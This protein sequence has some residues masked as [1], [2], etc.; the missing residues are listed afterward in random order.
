M[1]WD[2]NLDA[3]ESLKDL[4]E[5][6]EAARY[7]KVNR[8]NIACG[9]H[10]GDE[11]SMVKCLEL[12]KQFK[13]CAGAHPSFADRANF[14]RKKMALSPCE[15]QEL[16]RD[17]VGHLYEL[18]SKIGVSLTHVKPHGA[19]YQMAMSDLVLADAVGE[20]VREV[21]GNLILVGLAEAPAL[22]RWRQLGFGV[23]AEG[24]ADRG[25]QRDGTLVPRSE[26]GAVIT[27]P[28]QAVQ[29]MKNLLLT[30]KVKCLT[31]EWI[32]VTCQTV[33]IHGDNPSVDDILEAVSVSQQAG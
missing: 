31:G 32:S 25:Y 2:I 15:V 33:C 20:G 17:Q 27:D 12:A 10:A 21:D 3:G 5:G 4:A 23:L 11:T 28:S 16:V 7:K 18:A 8:I 6:S 9:G 19:L 13:L 29:Q 1:K 26:P 22:L 30:G 14:G 24:F